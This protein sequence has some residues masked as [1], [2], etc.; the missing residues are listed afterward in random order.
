MTG[1]AVPLIILRQIPVVFVMVI[2]GYIVSFWKISRIKRKM[3]RAEQGNSHNGRFLIAF[4]PILV[5]IVTA[6]ALS[7]LGNAYL[8]SQQGFD[9]LIATT[10]G[11][12]VLVLVSEMD[13][14]T[15][16]KPLKSWAIYGVTFAAYGAFF[17]RRTM[18]ASGIS[19]IFAPLVS[20]AYFDIL[21]LLVITPAV[22][23]ILTGSPQGGV[24]ISVPILSGL[25][26]FT[27]RTAAMIY[28]SAY[29]GYTISP[30]HLCLSFTAEYF[31]CSM[32][33]MYKYVIPSFL[34]T[35]ATALLIYSFF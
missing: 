25:L 22:F 31:G 8:L 33:K 15:F 3:K 28:I 2:V 29:L 4:S 20:N 34:V 13:F 17:L 16:T 35:F 14:V 6:V 26:A 18:I 24:A 7:A 32:R 21:L 1:V 30:T 5:A 10:V 19:T 27:P 23:G 11:V 9:V 12:V